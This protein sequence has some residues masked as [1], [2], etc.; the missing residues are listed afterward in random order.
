[1]GGSWG[2]MQPAGACLKCHLAAQ[3]RARGGRGVLW[4]ADL[5]GDAAAGFVGR[6]FAIAPRAMQIGAKDAGAAPASFAPG[7]NKIDRELN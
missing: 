4:W 6:Y 3:L 2:Q 5:W 7:F 1:M